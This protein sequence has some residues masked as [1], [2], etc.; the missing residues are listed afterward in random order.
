MADT[1]NPLERKERSLFNFI[2]LLTLEECNEL[3]DYIYNSSAYREYITTACLLKNAERTSDGYHIEIELKRTHKAL[4]N[5]RSVI[6][7]WCETN[8]G[9]KDG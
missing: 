9:E 2:C 3:I 5:L 1:E 7:S 4:I 8:V 6:K